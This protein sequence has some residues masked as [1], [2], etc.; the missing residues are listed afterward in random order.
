MPGLGFVSLTEY[1]LCKEISDKL[2]RTPK[3]TER[4]NAGVF[5]KAY[6]IAFDK[7]PCKSGLP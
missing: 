3:N 1:F 2:R 4:T 7:L 6:Y 5:T